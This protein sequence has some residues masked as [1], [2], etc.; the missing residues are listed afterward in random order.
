MPKKSEQRTPGA[1]AASPDLRPP[2]AEPRLGGGLRRSPPPLTR[3]QIRRMLDN[4]QRLRD[5]HAQEHGVQ[6]RGGGGE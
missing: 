2:S 5:L 3:E 4:T 1:L 6:G